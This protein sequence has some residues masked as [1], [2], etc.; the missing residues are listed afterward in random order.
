MTAARE[1]ARH[2]AFGAYE[3]GMSVTACD[4][5]SAARKLRAAGAEPEQAEAHAE[6]T[7]AAPHGARGDLAITADPD[8]AIAGPGNRTPRIAN[9][10]AAGRAAPTAAVIKSLT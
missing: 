7:V 3:G 5:L 1:P 2:A 6:I 4:T 8:A 10:T 9:A